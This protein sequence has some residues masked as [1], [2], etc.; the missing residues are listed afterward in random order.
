MRT[1]CQCAT[2]LSAPNLPKKTRGNLSRATSGAP[3][4]RRK[5]NHGHQPRSRRVRAAQQ[6]D[7]L[8]P[9][10]Q[11]SGLTGSPTTMMGRLACGFDLLLWGSGDVSLEDLPP[12]GSETWQWFI[13][14]NPRAMRAPLVADPKTEAAFRML[15]C[16]DDDVF[17]CSYPR[18]GLS[19]AHALSWHLLRSNE[20]GQ[21][22][23]RDATSVVGGKG[24]VYHD[25]PP[26][27][28][29]HQDVSGPGAPATIIRALCCGRLPPSFLTIK[30]AASSSSTGTRGMLSCRRSSGSRD[31]GRSSAASTATTPD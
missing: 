10:H 14:S 15:R 18:C 7:G 5:G 9:L 29:T 6:P 3:R 8:L 17:V 13:S 20:S 25:Q 4:A 24:P 2:G 12:H 16:R 26:T 28:W 27:K 21:L 30:S 23:F 31:L 11:R 22:P 19:W 1:R